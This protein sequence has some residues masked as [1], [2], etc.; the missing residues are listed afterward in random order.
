MELERLN[1]PHHNDH[2]SSSMNNYHH[3]HNQQQEYSD[4]IDH[5]RMSGSQYNISHSN[6]NDM[7]NR[8]NI[9][10]K[11][12]KQRRQVIRMVMSVLIVFYVCLFPLKTWNV[13]L[14]NV[15]STKGFF[16]KLDYNQFWFIN[17]ITRIFFYTNSSINP[18]LYNFLSKKFR[19]SF[20]KLLIFRI[21][22]SNV[23]KKSLLRAQTNSLYGSKK[24][25]NNNSNSMNEEHNK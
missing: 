23:N 11:Q 13:I 4:E 6:R 16:Q 18:I 21:C 5:Q 22:C 19:K 9:V 12:V 10:E 3:H 20:K 7:I 1:S 24:Y 8:K 15:S 25:D 2:I 14:M 17:I